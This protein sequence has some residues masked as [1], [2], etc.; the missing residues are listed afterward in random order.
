MSSRTTR[1]DT[2]DD[3]KPIL[4]ITGVSVPTSAPGPLQI[5]T[6][7]PPLPTPPGNVPAAYSRLFATCADQYAPAFTVRANAGAPVFV[8]AAFQASSPEPLI[9]PENRRSAVASYASPAS[10]EF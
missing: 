6:P 2:N 4:S 5:A 1:S 9:C 8:D 10:W 3:V 7:V